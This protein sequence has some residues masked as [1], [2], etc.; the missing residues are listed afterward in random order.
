MAT[1]TMPSTLSSLRPRPRTKT[2][3]LASQWRSKALALAHSRTVPVNP[4]QPPRCSHRAAAIALCALPRFGCAAD[5]ATLQPLPCRRQAAA[6]VALSRCHHHRSIHAPATTLPP[7]HC[8]PPPRFARRSIHVA[9]IALLL[10]RCAPP[11]LFPSPPPPLMLP[12]PPCRC[13]AFAPFLLFT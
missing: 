6:N 10:S 13:Q 3:T 7:S 8:A 5:A 4:P 11:P 1:T 2:R 12:L 9:A